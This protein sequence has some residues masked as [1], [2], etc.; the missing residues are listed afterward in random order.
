MGGTE[1]NGAEELAGTGKGLSLFAF[2]AGVNK[3]HCFALFIDAFSR[4]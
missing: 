4:V 2:T 1:G 3:V